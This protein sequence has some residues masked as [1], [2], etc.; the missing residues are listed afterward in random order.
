M[1]AGS[2]PGGRGFDP[3][4]PPATALPGL[5]FDL[6]PASRGTPAADLAFEQTLLVRARAGRSSLFLYRWPERVLVLGRGQDAGGVDAIRC[7]ALGIPILRRS[8]GGMGV[9][10]DG[11]FAV[12]LALSAGH[13]WA[14]SIPGLYDRFVTVL[15]AVLARLGVAVERGVAPVGPRT[16]ARSPLCFEDVLG[17]TLLVDG[18]KAVGCAQARR[19]GAVLVHGVIALGLDVATQSR[20]FGIPEERVRAAMAPVRLGPVAR[21][22]LPGEL[23]AAFARALGATADGDVA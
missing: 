13:P 20:V 22:S 3:A 14:R 6:F 17:E 4:F 21:A 1:I 19:A 23:A 10:H 8:S 2:A 7:A 16:R 11:D 18:R 12:S 5:P 9:L 15:G